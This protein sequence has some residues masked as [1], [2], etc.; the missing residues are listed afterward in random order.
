MP[1][2]NRRSF[3][4]IALGL[5]A[6]QD[7]PS[8][9]LIVVDNG[10]DRV[11]DLCRGVARVR[12]VFGAKHA[13]IGAQR[14]HACAHARGD[15]IVH[16]D[17]D[18]WYAPD[19]LRRQLAPIEAGR[20]DVTGIENRYTLDL[21]DLSFWGLTEALHRRMWVGNVHGGTLAYRRTFLAQ[22]VRYPDVSLAEDAVLLR[23]L[24]RA[25]ARLERVENEELFVYV[26]HGRNSWQFQTGAL[27][28]RAGWRRI[29]AP[30]RMTPAELGPYRRPDGAPPAGPA[31]TSDA[32]GMV[33]IA[34]GRRV[35][36][37]ERCVVTAAM[38]DEAEQL[39]G[40][41]TSLARHGRLIGVPPVVVIDER[42]RRCED[43][44]R[45]HGALVL[46]CRVA[47]APATIKAVLG[48]LPA[49]VEA[50]RYLY[51][52]PSALAVGGLDPL[53]AEA[54][55][56]PGEVRLA[57]DHEGPWG[58]GGIDEPVFV[59]DR[60]ALSR[61]DAFLRARPEIGA[62]VREA[63][64]SPARLSA[65]FAGALAALQIGAPLPGVLDPGADHLV[66]GHLT[67]GRGGQI[68]CVEGAVRVVRFAGAGDPAFE[69]WR[70]LVVAAA[71]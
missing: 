30:A 69:R 62:W 45:R 25:G 55:G 61:V 6:R 17:D 21:G 2:A 10:D 39:G 5:F 49:V 36:R 52:P 32:L 19:R 50:E 65:A 67:G 4:R 56:A 68:S 1:T 71:G 8:A 59:A 66:K 43:V 51:L 70:P 34:S 58:S 35:P 33:D 41:L 37:F 24:L 18:D 23:M 57:G 31:P 26:R 40:M 16:W 46:R 60:R 38:E 27:H 11:E 63:P 7:H 13:S 14:N 54:A 20:A 64:E 47:G 42:A 22:G 44:A 53:F 3:V 48:S 29:A 9:E 12:Y 15:V 28:D